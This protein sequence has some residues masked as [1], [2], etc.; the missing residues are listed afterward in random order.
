MAGARGGKWTSVLLLGGAKRE[1]GML[2]NRLYIGERVWN[3]QRFV[4]D[5]ST[6][7]RVA[8]IN[9]REA[10]IVTQVPKLA[11]IDQE[12]WAA[13]QARLEAGL[14][15]MA[16]PDVLPGDEAS[17]PAPNRGA[18]LAA[19]RRPAWLLAGLVRCG[20]CR[21]SL[22]V[23]GSV[24]RLGCAKCGEI[25]VQLRGDL[26]AFLHLG[27]PGGAGGQNNKTAVLRVENGRS[28]RTGEVMGTLD[29]GTGFG[30]CRTALR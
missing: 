16:V 5:P 7:K 9:P 12:L 28:G 24:G 14:R 19:V 11:I 23:M 18:R 2:R 20:L 21:G 22:T 27:E 10:W 6:G 8:R 17:L 15:I 30:L 13:T 3:R 1:T 26:A 25:S 29:A 4:K